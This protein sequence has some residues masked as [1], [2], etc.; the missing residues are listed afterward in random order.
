LASVVGGSIVGLDSVAPGLLRSLGLAGP[1]MS[2]SLTFSLA[3]GAVFAACGAVFAR[4]PAGGSLL[5]AD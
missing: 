1:G 3:L 2:A 5:L 4:R